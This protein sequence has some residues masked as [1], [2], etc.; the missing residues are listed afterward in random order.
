[1]SNYIKVGALWSKTR[2]GKKMLTGNIEIEGKKFNVTVISNSYRTTDKHP[3]YIVT[4]FRDEL[5]E[6]GIKFRDYSKEHSNDP[7]TDDNIPF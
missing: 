6:K 2:N 3:E 7:V 4:A 1:M 5:N